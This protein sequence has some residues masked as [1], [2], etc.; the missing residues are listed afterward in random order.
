[1]EIRQLRYFVKIA[2]LGSVSRASLALHI[3]QP[4]LSQQMAQLEAELGQALLLRSRSGVSMT[5]AGEAFYRHAQRILRELSDLPRAVMNAGDGLS[6]TVT[7]GLPQS[8]AARF[9]MPLLE[10]LAREH[11]GIE[12]S[13]F[14]EISGNVLRHLRGGR[15]DLGVVVHD[16]DAALVEA[17]HLM[18]EQLFVAAAPGLLAHWLDLPS[19]PHEPLGLE[20]LARLPLALPSREHGVRLLVEQALLARQIQLPRTRITANSMPI[21]LQAARAGLA[22]TVA[23]WAALADDLQRGSLHALTLAPSLARRVHVCH[24]AEMPLGSAAQAVLDLLVRTTREAVMQGDWQGVL[25]PEG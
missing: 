12:L 24:H 1:M 15:L 8:N 4:A 20:L 3:A 21:M 22:A 25:L 16:A 7:L 13:L 18:D 6:G 5:S 10:R 17:I 19:D 2:D 9:A 23:P 14:E 11:P